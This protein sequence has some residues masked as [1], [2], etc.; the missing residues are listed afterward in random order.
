M[1]FVSY[2]KDTGAFTW[3]KK[4]SA[5]VSIGDV[6]GSVDKCGRVK[7]ML[8]GRQ[9]F[10]HRVAFLYMT[11]S[12]PKGVVDHID[13]NPLNN[14]WENLRD[15]SSR[16]N[17]ENRRTHQSNNLLKRLGVYRKTLKSGKVKYVARIRVNGELRHVG[18]F[19]SEDCAYLAYLNEK[20]KLHKGCTL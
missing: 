17:S 5:G 10:A 6:A 7:F 12:F 8:G 16:E 20:R 9:Y 3:I 11:G 14:S 2:N 1:S 18:V 13:G 19:D 4:P 15:V